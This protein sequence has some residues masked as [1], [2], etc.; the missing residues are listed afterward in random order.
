[1]GWWAPLWTGMWVQES[2]HQSD[3]HSCGEGY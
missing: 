1:M 2:M 3:G